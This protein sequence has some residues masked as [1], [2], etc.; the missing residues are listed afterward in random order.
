MIQLPS[1]AVYPSDPTSGDPA[2]VSWAFLGGDA[3]LTTLHVEPEHR[4]RGLAK[5][6]A[7]KLFAEDMQSF[8]T[9]GDLTEEDKDKDRRWAHADVAV[10]NDASIGVC[11]SLGGKWEWQVYWVRIDLEK[12]RSQVGF[13]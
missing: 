6:V 11:T 7:M 10:D 12:Q 8:V 2:P 13:L 5:A 1:V 9:H 4:G 3:S